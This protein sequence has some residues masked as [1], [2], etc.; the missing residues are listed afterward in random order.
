MKNLSLE[1]QETLVNLISEVT[2]NCMH[3]LEFDDTKDDL[4]IS[5]L[6]AALNKISEERM[7]YYQVSNVLIIVHSFTPPS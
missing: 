7:L 2:K 6:F 1:N 3:P 4:N 5:S